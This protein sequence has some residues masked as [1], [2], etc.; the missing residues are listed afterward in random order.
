MA[1]LHPCRRAVLG[2]LALVPATAMAR[3]RHWPH[4]KRGAVSLTYDDG[5]NSQLDNVIPAL[6]ARDLKGTFF[7]VRDNVDERID[8]WVKVAAMGHEIGNHTMTHDCSLANFTQTA[9]AEREIAPMEAYLDAHFGAR[10]VR[11]F[12]YPCGFLG[13]GRGA[14]RQRFARYRV[15]LETSVDCARTVTGPPNDPDAVL[16]DRLNLSG[17]E[18]TY[19]SESPEPARRYLDASVARG[20]W[21]ILIFH[22]VLPRRQGEGDTAIAVHERILDMIAERPLWCAPMGEVFARLAR[23]KT[24]RHT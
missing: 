20:A 15:A 5:L 22:E 21:A 14:M 4:H 18:P 3:A 9:F 19:D 7:L 16:A 13:L 2:G 8:D 17:F 10:P 24:V 1:P 11:S 6:Q 12:A 23:P